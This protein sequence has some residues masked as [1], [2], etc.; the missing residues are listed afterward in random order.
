MYRIGIVQRKSQANVSV[1]LHIPDNPV[2]SM[3]ALHTIAKQQDQTLLLL[4]SARWLRGLPLSDS[5]Q[6]RT[7]YEFLSENEEDHLTTVIARSGQRSPR[8]KALPAIEVRPEDRWEDVKMFFD[9]S[10]GRL[11]V[12]IGQR[13][14][15]VVVWNTAKRSR[16]ES[17]APRFAFILAKL[18]VANPQIWSNASITPS[19]VETMRKGFQLLKKCLAQWVPIADGEPFV[20]DRETR[21]HRPRFSLE[22][23]QH[24]SSHVSHAAKNR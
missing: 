11:R 17:G 1:I 18:A 3:A 20:Y 24:A 23:K 7:I 9:P 6:V 5:V 22:M 2:T 8:Q 4:P 21:S 13:R 15:S 14:L 10:A 19:E 16:R 12:L